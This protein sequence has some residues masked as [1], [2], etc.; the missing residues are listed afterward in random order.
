MVDRRVMAAVWGPGDPATSLV[1]LDPQVTLS[2]LELE[3]PHLKGHNICKLSIASS[4]AQ[5]ATPLVIAGS[6][7][8][9]LCNVWLHFGMAS[10]PAH[11]VMTSSAS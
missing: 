8:D 10:S 2:E 11:L 7:G 3:A 9:A 1:M 6:A 4:P 5:P